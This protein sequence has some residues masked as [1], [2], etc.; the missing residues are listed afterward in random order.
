MAGVLSAGKAIPMLPARDGDETIAFY[1]RL[2]FQLGRPHAE[3]RTYIVGGR[4]PLELHFFEHPAVE[5][6]HNLGGCYLLVADAQTLYEEWEPLG[7]RCLAPADTPWGT[8]EFS[9]LDPSGNLIRIGSTLR[10][11]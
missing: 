9:V 3:D 8:R 6:L 7:L 1:S 11:G 2:G 10:D 5:P 4:G